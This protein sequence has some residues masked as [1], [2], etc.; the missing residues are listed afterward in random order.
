MKSWPWRYQT[1]TLMS[2]P[3]GALTA[4][5]TGTLTTIAVLVQ[6][7]IFAVVVPNWTEPAVPKPL[8]RMVTLEP[9]APWLT[10]NERMCAVVTGGVTT[11]GVATGGVTTGGV[12]TGGVVTG[13]VVTGGVVT[14]GVVTGGVVTGGVVGAAATVMV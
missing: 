11:G 1:G 6:D 14:G 5:L 7:E 2:E 3:E 8:P 4:D 9:T 12:V 10:D 13:G